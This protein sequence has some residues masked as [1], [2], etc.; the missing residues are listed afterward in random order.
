MQ[1]NQDGKE[2]DMLEDVKEGQ[3]SARRVS[4]GRSLGFTLGATGNH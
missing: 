4:E 2:L 1:R 3:N